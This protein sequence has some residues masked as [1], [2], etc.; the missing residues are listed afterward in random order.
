MKI[1]LAK[2]LET[3]KKI[4]EEAASH[5]T[6]LEQQFQAA[7][8]AKDQTAARLK[9][10][11]DQLKKLETPPSKEGEAEQPAEKPAEDGEAEKSA[12]D[13]EAAEGDQAA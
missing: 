10:I 11:E 8:E 5:A 6:A 7:R 12:E 4:A 1:R 13:D 9:E 2:E 3:A